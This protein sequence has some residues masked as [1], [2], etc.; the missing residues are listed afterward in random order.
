M[1]SIR[2]YL[3]DIRYVINANSPAQLKMFIFRYKRQDPNL[4]V[5]LNLD[6]RALKLYLYYL[7]KEVLPLIEKHL[8]CCSDEVFH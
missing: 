1:Q 2:T 5:L 6:R 8:E 4:Q 7:K 3:E